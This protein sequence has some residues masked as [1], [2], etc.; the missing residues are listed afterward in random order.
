MNCIIA[1]LMSVAICMSTL[2]CTLSVEAKENV[3]IIYTDNM[4]AVGLA[5]GCSHG[6][7]K[8]IIYMMQ[9]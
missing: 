2:A 7:V 6:S 4:Y 8:V 9:K 5:A 1:R 3:G